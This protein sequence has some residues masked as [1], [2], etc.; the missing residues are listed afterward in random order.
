MTV[1]CTCSPQWRPTISSVWSPTQSQRTSGS[2]AASTPPSRG[3]PL[4]Q[5]VDGEH[6]RGSDRLRRPPPRPGCARSTIASSAALQR[7]VGVDDRRRTA[8][9]RPRARSPPAEA[10]ARRPSRASRGRARR[11]A[12][13][14]G[15]VLGH[16]RPGLVRRRAAA[17]TTGPGLSSASAH[18]H[19]R[20][21]LD[22]P[23]V[24]QEVG[25]EV[26]GRRP[27]AAPPA[28][29]PARRRRRRCR[30]A[31][32][33]ASLIASSMSWVTSTIVLCTR[34]WRA[35]SSSWSRARTMGST[36]RVRLVHQQHRRV[37]G[38]RPGDAD[39]L[40][41]AARQRGRVA[42]EQVGVELRPARPARRPAR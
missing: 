19:E 28:G 14:V 32:R 25:H 39:P 8:R 13:P 35:S 21:P 1:S 11:H 36:A 42:V 20:Q 37:G 24:A 31:M 5:V 38:E 4:G 10:R 6:A 41:L 33:S 27:A 22:A 23:V 34:C 2:S 17:P 30:M 3:H 40:L 12:D 15:A 7:G 9:P 16:D 26:V 18:P 29:R